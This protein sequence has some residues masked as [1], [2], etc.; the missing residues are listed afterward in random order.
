MFA[1]KKFKKNTFKSCSEKSN[2]LWFMKLTDAKDQYLFMN[3]AE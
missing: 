3:Q 1:H 2:P